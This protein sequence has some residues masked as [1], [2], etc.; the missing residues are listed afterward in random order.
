MGYSTQIM[1]REHFPEDRNEARALI[2]SFRGAARSIRDGFA[3][4]LRDWRREERTKRLS[5]GA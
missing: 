5:A 1:S 4:I 3:R 2:K